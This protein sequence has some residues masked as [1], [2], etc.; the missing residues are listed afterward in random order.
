MSPVPSEEPKSRETLNSNASTAW[1]RAG[2]T[3]PRIAS[4]TRKTY[5]QFFFMSLSPSGQDRLALE[6]GYNQVD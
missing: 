5:K 4:K 2:V 1:A 3:N 6:N